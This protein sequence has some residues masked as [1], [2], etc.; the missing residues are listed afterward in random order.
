MRILISGASR[1]IGR[2]LVSEALA[3][4]FEVDAIVRKAEDAPPGC[5]VHVLDV[6]DHEAIAQLMHTLAPLLDCYIANAGVGDTLNPRKAD[7]GDRAVRQIQINTTSTIYSC[8]RIAFE[9]IELGLRDRRIAMVSSLGAGRGFPSNSVYIASKTALI[10]FAQGFEID[11]AKHGIGVSLILPGFVDT[12]MT[13][14]LKSKP[15]SVKPA[16]AAR[17]ILNG[18][19][20]KKF[21]IAFPF[22]IIWMARFRDFIPYFLFRWIVTGMQKLKWV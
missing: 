18:I 22:P 11:L 20:R 10:S 1:G 21:W 8:Y 17:I 5:T 7:S 6:T 19:E 12:D 3:L 14:H 16:A 2:S 13:A 15:F 4:G 9:W